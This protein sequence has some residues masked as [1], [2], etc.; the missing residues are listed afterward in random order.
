MSSAVLFYNE[1]TPVNEERHQKWSV[2]TGSTYAF[3]RRTNSVPLTAVEFPAAAHEYVIVFASGDNAETFPVVILGIEDKQNLYI[4]DDGGWKAS[5]IPA[6]VRRYP[7]IFASDEKGETFTLCID[8]GFAGCNQEGRGQQ[9][10]EGKGKRS[11]YLDGV[12][13][14]LKEFQLQHQ[15]T[16]AFCQR[17][18]ELELLEP[19][20]ANVSLK[21]GAKMSLAGFQ[22]ISREKL[23]S[24][25][26]KTII[27]LLKSDELE[28]VFNHLHSLRN[29]GPM[30]DR[31]AG[32]SKE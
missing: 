17:L 12:L 19:M 13:A 2:E 3:A 31:L 16:R 5:Y 29:F 30:V 23:K 21:S 11:K 22:V 1:A 28:L 15:R 18:K 9:L 25:P 7:F 6:F 8:E 27:E 24:I 14:F 10:F 20:Q 4:S 26:E 32:L